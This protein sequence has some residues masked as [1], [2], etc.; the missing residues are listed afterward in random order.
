[1]QCATFSKSLNPRNIDRSFSDI[2]IRIRFPFES[3]FWISLS[4]CNLTTL[5]D[6]RPANWCQAK[7]LTC[8]ISDFTPCTHAKSNILHTK[9]VDKTDYYGLGIRV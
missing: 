5:P 4:G 8:K 2:R 3:S 9:Y 1:M 6:I 7:F